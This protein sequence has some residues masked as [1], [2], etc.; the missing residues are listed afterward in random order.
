MRVLP[1]NS[2]PSSV[3]L[4]PSAQ[5]VPVSSEEASDFGSRL[6][7]SAAE[8]SAGRA[9]P[10]R[11]AFV[12]ARRTELSGTQ[13]AKALASAFEQSQ[14]VAPSEGTLAVL[15]AHW[16]HET[17]RGQAMLNFNFGGIKGRSPE[18][19]TTHYTTHEG[20]GAERHKAVDGFRA[21]ESAASG[22]ADYIGLLER[23]YPAALRAAAQA[24]PGQFVRALHEGGYFT[25]H[26]ASY[27]R[28]IRSLAR[29]A[30]RGGVEALSA[31][32]VT[33]GKGSS[34]AAPASDADRP[35]AASTIAAASFVEHWPSVLEHGRATRAG[36][37]EPSPMK[38]LEV[39]NG[40]L[41]A[42]AV[43]RAVTQLLARNDNR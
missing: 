22:A 13:A 42:D 25:A 20:H 36:A 6:R 2:P 28:S 30:L 19:L 37:E 16:A 11:S 9:G 18:G 17:G 29:T 24:R 33:E 10:A 34:P 3:S 14:G 43:E 7:A 12:A 1:L 21:Y 15:T 31:A 27:E 32:G 26:P 35:S 41:A 38:I 40:Q 4:V 23:R 39:W 5:A 8:A